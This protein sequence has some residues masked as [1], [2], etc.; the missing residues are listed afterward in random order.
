MKRV[1]IH[2]VRGGSYCKTKLTIEDYKRISIVLKSVEDKCFKCN[3]KKHF[4]N[5]CDVGEIATFDVNESIY[6][7]EQDISF[8]Y[9]INEDGKKQPCYIF[10]KH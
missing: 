5:N 2:K 1:G 4:T 8:T 7:I 10:K 3:S 9:R 6:E